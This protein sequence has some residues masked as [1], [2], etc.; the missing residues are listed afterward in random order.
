VAK[1]DEEF[2]EDED[3][4]AIPEGVDAEPEIELVPTEETI[5]DILHRQLAHMRWTNVALL[6]ITALSTY[7][8]FNA[9]STRYDVPMYVY[10]QSTGQAGIANPNG[11]QAEGYLSTVSQAVSQVNTWDVKTFSKTIA[12]V[13]DRFGDAIIKAM[14]KNYADRSSVWAVDGYSQSL[15]LDSAYWPQGSNGDLLKWVPGMNTFKIRLEG[16]FT[17]SARGESKSKKVKLEAL[18]RFVTGSVKH[19][20]GLI[21]TSINA[22]K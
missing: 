12:L 20:H 1:D 4:L 18:C 8:M 15:T 13:K 11:Y 19:P 7:A 21:I 3:E 6:V 5:V 9:Y 14:D 17:R 2:I 22:V 10:N 16:T